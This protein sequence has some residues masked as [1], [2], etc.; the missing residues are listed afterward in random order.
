LIA[1]GKSNWRAHSYLIWADNLIEIGKS[2]SVRGLIAGERTD[3]EQSSRLALY[4]PGLDGAEV[5]RLESGS[6]RRVKRDE[7]RESVGKKGE[8]LCTWKNLRSAGFVRDAAE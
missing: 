1:E 8:Q 3:F 6:I 7:V 4:L 5:I 2:W